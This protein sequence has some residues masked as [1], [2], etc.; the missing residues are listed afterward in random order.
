MTF[1][2]FT[3]VSDAIDEEPDLLTLDEVPTGLVNEEDQARLEESVAVLQ[4]I[5]GVEEITGNA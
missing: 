5:A 2:D 1:E 3:L 4:E